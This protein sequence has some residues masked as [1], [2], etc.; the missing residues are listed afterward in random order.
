MT[1]TNTASDGSLARPLFFFDLTSDQMTY[2]NVTGISYETPPQMT[3][4][5]VTESK[6]SND[7][8]R[9]TTKE[10]IVPPPFPKTG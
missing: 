4:T 2:T 6:S 1:T 7:K 10:K 9:G 5:N 8:Q 3:Y